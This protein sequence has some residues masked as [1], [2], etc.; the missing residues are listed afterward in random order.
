MEQDH[1]YGTAHAAATAADDFSVEDL[2]KVLE[3]KLD[4]VQTDVDPHENWLEGE[5]DLFG[6]EELFQ[7]IH[8]EDQH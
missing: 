6:T 5:G 1:L 3:Q 2:D 7:D 8:S 4:G